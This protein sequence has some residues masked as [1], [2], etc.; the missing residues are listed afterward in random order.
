[1]RAILAR[2]VDENLPGGFLRARSREHCIKNEPQDRKLQATGS[3]IG[4]DIGSLLEALD[5]KLHSSSC[6]GLGT[7]M[8]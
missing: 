1:M 8:N 3:Q 5:G 2:T 4:Q 6:K 7:L